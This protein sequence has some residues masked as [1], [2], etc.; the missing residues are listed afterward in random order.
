MEGEDIVAAA[1]YENTIEELENEVTRWKMARR[2]MTVPR[3]DKLV[4][5][6][7]VP[8]SRRAGHQGWKDQMLGIEV[9]I[10]PTK[11]SIYT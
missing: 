8:P 4:A 10:I 5:R 9:A 6:R 2:G 11:L 7:K 1:N 3:R